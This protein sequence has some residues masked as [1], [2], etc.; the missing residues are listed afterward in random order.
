MNSNDD[1]FRKP[2]I[3][4]ERHTAS[5]KPIR[6]I[7]F[8]FQGWLVFWLA[9][10]LA[11]VFPEPSRSQTKEPVL[12]MELGTHNASIFGLAGDS[13]SRIL[14]TGSEDKTVRVW[15][16]SSGARLLRVLRPPVG[17]GEQG[18][19]FAVGLAPDGR[20]IAC[21]GR[22]GEPQQGEGCV[23]LFD[24]ETGALI[25]RLGG[26]RGWV[27]HLAYTAD[28]RFLAAV[29]S[30]RGGKVDWTGM[31][32]FR[33]PDYALVAEDR[34]YGN[35]IR[36]VQSD[37]SGAKLATSCLDGFVRLY[38]LSALK[39]LTAASSMKL[40][41]VSTIGFP[42]AALPWGLAFSPDGTRLAVGFHLVP[43][44]DV[45]EVNG[46]TL[47]PAYTPD[48]TGAM[49]GMERDFMAVAWSH[50]GRFLYAG[51]GH[52]L[53]KDRQIRKWADGGRG[54]YRDLPVGVELSIPSILPLAAG[55]IIYASRDGSF[56]F[57]NERDETTPLS[58]KVIPIYAAN[59]KG[60]LISPDGSAVQF[61]YERGGKSPAI[62]A[63]NERQLTD[64]ASN[65]WAGL[66]AGLT[67][68][69]PVTEGLEISDWETSLSP[70]LRGRPLQLNQ[71]VA[72]CLAIKP[73]LTGFLMGTT[74]ALRLF[75]SSGKM[76]WRVRMP[77]VVWAVN[78][79]GRV[80]VAALGDGTIRWYRL[81]DGEEILALFP[82]PDR[83]RWILWTPSG[84][85]DASPGGE[86]FI[87]WHV[88]SGKE[89]AA[90]F[91][92]ASR[93]RS[94]HYRPD[95]IDRVLQT[96]DEHEA[97]R[98]ANADA[99]RT[100]KVKT[101]VIEILPPV[102]SIAAPVD[103]APV[104]ATPVKVRY[105]ARSR[106]AL[107]KLL[108]LVDGRPVAFEGGDKA[109]KESGELNVAIPSRDCEV[110]VVAENRYAASQPAT[111]RLRWQGPAAKEEFEIKP[112]LYVLAVGVSNYQTQDMRLDLAAKDAVDFGAVW[113]EQKGRL[114]SGVEVRVLTD[115]QANKGNILDGLEWLQRQVTAKDV[116]VL[117]F[118]GHGINDGTGL[119]YFL[120]VDADLEKLKRTGIS[121][122]DITS[123]V[124]SL[125]GKVLVFMDACHSGNLMGKLKRR[126]VVVVSSVINELAS[127]E[128][129]AVV[130]SSATGRQYALE[131]AEWGNGAFT[132]G[133]VE[134]VR[135]KADYRSTGRITVNM[136][137]LY[138]S[139]RVKELTQGQQTPT[140]VKP[141]NVPDF[142]VALVR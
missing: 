69:A 76:L 52:R 127:A 33:L 30:E 35:F 64:T 78:T 38:D 130:F 58:P 124:A 50:D 140:T 97:L 27:Q 23:Y 62:F 91:F 106:E 59:E 6:F 113:K 41:P 99:G 137:D 16:I 101:S 89:Q 13:S 55:G 32:I 4:A 9:A 49:G 20:T 136:L 126:D 123:T 104:S 92:P 1:L 68:K 22:T 141:P 87:G 75:D 142:P 93:F 128:N 139:E 85:Y 114:Y 2:R 70:K 47:A 132:K 90:D 83:K 7:R 94:T 3:R 86:D 96:L 122:A 74:H 82:H 17:D 65:L 118:A 125:A 61:A 45:L 8:R 66:K 42:G 81:T 63:V 133:V 25:R 48:A 36:W 107:T 71:E 54:K 26:L 31:S 77:G 98:L 51:G 39:S 117:F 135:G 37:P 119:F 67:F 21:G 44:V 95:V 121:Q 100:P 24:R 72:K 18:Q 12:R 56:G 43:R 79:N 120:P 109:P 29:V 10:L 134:G 11:L 28:G 53:K 111:I 112:K 60:L 110:S 73:D 40:A 138:V 131:K 115:A 19:I 5:A 108:V 88:N 102:V 34:G 84:Y 80:T 116:A 15:D 14:V 129:G 103:G 105:S 46:N 57:V